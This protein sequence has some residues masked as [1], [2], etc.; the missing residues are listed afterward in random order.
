MR[1]VYNFSRFVNKY[2]REN[3]NVIKRGPSW[4]RTNQEANR[5]NQTPANLEDSESAKEMGRKCQTKTNNHNIGRGGFSPVLEEKRRKIRKNHPL[6]AGL[7]PSPSLDSPLTSDF[8]ISL[9]LTYI[10]ISQLSS[11]PSSSNSSSLQ[12]SSRQVNPTPER[13]SAMLRFA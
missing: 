4:N 7:L 6:P 3:C 5:P 13:P 10:Q 1:W 8:A 2:S 9:A 11:L 12:V